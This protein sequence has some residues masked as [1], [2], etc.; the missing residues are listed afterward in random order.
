[1]G[2]GEARGEADLGQ[3]IKN[4]AAGAQF[5]VAK[6]EWAVNRVEGTLLGWCTPGLRCWEGGIG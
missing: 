1:M 6:C 3:N 4:Q 5:G 2:S